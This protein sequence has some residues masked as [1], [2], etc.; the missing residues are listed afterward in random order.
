MTQSTELAT[1]EATLRDGTPVALRRITPA[2]APLLEEA[3]ARLSE[4]SR[5]LRFLTAKPTLSQA[6]LHYLTHVDGHNHEALVA[7]DPATGYGVGI[8]RW[9]RE[10]EDRS[11]AEVAVTV[12]DEWQGRGVGTLLLEHL[13]ERARQEGVSTFT[14]LVAADNVNMQR[15]LKHLDAPVQQIKP[16]GEAAEYEIAVGTKGL[17]ARLQ[18]ALRAA[19]EGNLRVPPRLWEALRSLVPLPLHR[20]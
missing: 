5:R 1:T 4:E 19:A 17:A 3:F 10:R 2:D 9:V 14:A 13:S 16:L 18:D 8:G 12:A 15:L 11:R 7:I 20:R 6:E